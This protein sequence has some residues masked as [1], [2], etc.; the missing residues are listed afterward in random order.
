[1]EKETL[2]EEKY[3]DDVYYWGKK[4]SSSCFKVMEMKPPVEKLKLL[5]LGCGEGKNAVF[6]ARNGYD[7]T[8]FDLSEKGV[9]KNEKICF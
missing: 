9:K 4:P 8:A 6:F 3:S 7:V 5:V 1:M 2:Y